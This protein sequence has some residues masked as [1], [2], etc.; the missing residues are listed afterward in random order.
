MTVM[1]FTEARHSL[2][3]DLR[4]SLLN[5]FNIIICSDGLASESSKHKIDFTV[6]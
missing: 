1:P 4:F 3:I 5:L 6:N 2:N